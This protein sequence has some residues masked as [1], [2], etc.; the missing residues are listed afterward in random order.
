MAQDHLDSLSGVDAS[1]LHQEGSSTH[2]H[3]GGIA[4]LEGSAPPYTEL[5]GHIRDRLHLVPR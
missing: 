4:L 3:I 2:M 5:C 1:F